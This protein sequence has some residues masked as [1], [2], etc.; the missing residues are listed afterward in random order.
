VKPQEDPIC[1]LV[2]RSEAFFE[3]VRGTRRIEM[4]RAEKIIDELLG[5]PD[6]R[7]PLAPEDLYLGD[8]E[9]WLAQHSILAASINLSLLP[10]EFTELGKRGY[11]LAGLLHD[12]G[13]VFVGGATLTASRALAPE[14]RMEM[15]RH[16]RI[17]HA[18]ISSAG[19]NYAELAMVA[20]DHHERLDGSGYPSGLRTDQLGRLVRVTGLVDSYCALV[21]RRPYRGMVSPGAALERLA[22]ATEMG[23]Y[24]P[25]LFPVLHQACHPQHLG[26]QGLRVP[27]SP[28]TR[29]DNT[30]ARKNPLALEFY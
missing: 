13:M 7:L 6:G 2:R 19:K 28:H 20:R 16:T 5:L 3:D 26:A 4:R 23:V 22:R 30:P 9:T 1:E 12:V 14:Q 29:A 21:G 15:Q 10:D 11:G 18:L 8:Q 17:G 24:D 27:D 25:T